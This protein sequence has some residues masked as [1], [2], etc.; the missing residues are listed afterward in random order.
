MRDGVLK[1]GVCTAPLIL[2]EREYL[3]VISSWIEQLERF[4]DLEFEASV[5]FD[6]AAAALSSFPSFKSFSRASKRQIL[7]LLPKFPVDR[8][9]CQ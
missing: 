1:Q 2:K 4:V 6:R 3:C 5:S 9:P 8:F 7:P